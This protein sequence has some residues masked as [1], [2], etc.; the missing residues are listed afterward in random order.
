[1]DRRET[2]K[3]AHIDDEDDGLETVVDHG[4]NLLDRQL[5]AAFSGDEDCAASRTDLLSSHVFESEVR[6]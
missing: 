2:K 6:A 5:H 3:D 1:M 4:T